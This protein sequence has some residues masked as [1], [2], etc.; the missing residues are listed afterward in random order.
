MAR[1][2][3]LYNPAARRA[4]D[5]GLLE[6]IAEKLSGA[7]FALELRASDRPGHL[8]ELGRL[9]GRHCDRVVVCGGDGSVREVA[10]GLFGSP[11]PLA[12]IPLG[13]VNVLAHEMGLPARDLSACA[14]VAA[15]GKPHPVGLGTVGGRAFTFNA[16]CGLDSL[17]VAGVNLDLKSRTGR[18]AYGAAALKSLLEGNLPTFEVETESGERLEA[19][20]V[21]AARA[22]RYAGK[23]ILLSPLADLSSPTMRLIALPPP[24]HRHAGALLRLFGEGLD[25][26]PGTIC[27]EARAF[28]LRSD[29]PLTV[30]ADGDF[31]PGT[32]PEF[33]SHAD[34]LRLVFPD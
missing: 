5:E 12:V 10:E 29:A 13:T 28:R 24:I 7:G 21:F 11:V 1:A 32:K 19:C 8:T 20:Q 3:L 16:S 27:R 33:E 6:R 22:H 4:P 26:A 18:L 23:G 25:G 15:M 34:A 30:Q 14:E 2:L 17:A 31:M 9:G